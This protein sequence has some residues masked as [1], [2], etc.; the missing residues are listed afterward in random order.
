MPPITWLIR[1]DESVRFATGDFASGYRLRQEL[2]NSLASRGHQLGWHMHDYRARPRLGLAARDVVRLDDRF[3]L[4][5]KLAPLETAWRAGELG[6]LWDR[7]S[8][9]G[10][11][12][13]LRRSQSRGAD[14]P[15]RQWRRQGRE[16]PPGLDP[17]GGRQP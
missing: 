7:Q 11:D 13:G 15:D 2:W 4:H 17:D 14:G 3:G 8:R 5:P 16:T 1:S 10:S 6:L 12:R 9:R